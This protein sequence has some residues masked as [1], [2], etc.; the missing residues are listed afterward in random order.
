MSHNYTFDKIVTTMVLSRNDEFI[1]TVIP[2]IL[3]EINS[4]LISNLLLNICSIFILRKTGVSN[5]SKLS[6]YFAA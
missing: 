2:L 4:F 3:F 5:Y 1:N 6:L